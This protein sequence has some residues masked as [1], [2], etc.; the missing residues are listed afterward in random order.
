MF[1]FLNIKQRKNT[2][3]ID[4]YDQSYDLLFK[5]FLHNVTMLNIIISLTFIMKQYLSHN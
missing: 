1:D 4:H 5:I 3:V 2:T